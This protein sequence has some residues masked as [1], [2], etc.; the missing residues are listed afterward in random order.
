MAVVGG[1]IFYEIV[2]NEIHVSSVKKTILSE[3]R[4]ILEIEVIEEVSCQVVE[5][6]FDYYLGATFNDLVKNIMEI[7]NY[8]TNSDQV[9]FRTKVL[10]GLLDTKVNEDTD[11]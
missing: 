6:F 10:L 8:K 5:K 4:Q 7:R 3:S 1:I 11:A 2:K 9:P